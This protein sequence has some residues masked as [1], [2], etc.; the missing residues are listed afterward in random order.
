MDNNLGEHKVTDRVP[1][2]VDAK[3]LGGIIFMHAF[4][5]GVITAIIDDPYHT[6]DERVREIR[7]TLSDL[8]KVWSDGSISD[9]YRQEKALRANGE[10]REKKSLRLYHGSRKSSR[11]ILKG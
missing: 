8:K 1:W 5:V 2:F 4:A 6:A 7:G 3:E 11:S 10:P 9:G